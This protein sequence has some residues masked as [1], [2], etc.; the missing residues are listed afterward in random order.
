M[1]WKL[2]AAGLQMTYRILKLGL[3]TSFIITSYTSIAY[4]ILCSIYTI[5]MLTL[6]FV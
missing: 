6:E 4:A 5:E 2:Q 3:Q 1:Q